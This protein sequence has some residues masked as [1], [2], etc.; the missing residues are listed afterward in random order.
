MKEQVQK[1]QFKSSHISHIQGMRRPA[2]D[3]ELY[4]LAI[5]EYD[6]GIVSKDK[7]LADKKNKIVDY[8]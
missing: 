1:P 8:M 5:K 7:V 2:N 6:Q 3:R 4:A